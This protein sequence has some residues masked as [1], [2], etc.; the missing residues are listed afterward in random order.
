MA[1]GGLKQVIDS[2]CLPIKPKMK[3]AILDMI[4]EM[5]SI[6]VETSQKSQS[7][8]KNYLAMLLKALIHCNL[9]NCLTQL[10]IEKSDSMA[11]RARKLLKLVITAASDLLPDAPQF[12]LMLDSK[13]SVIAAEIV[14]EIDSS[15]RLQLNSSHQSI[16]FRSCEF[17]SKEPNSYIESHNTVITGIYKNHALNMID[18]TIFNTLMQKSLVLKESITT[19][20]N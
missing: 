9:Y 1:S 15:T 17:L 11:Q 16:L 7:L 5:I 6:P 3:E 4:E 18:D 12:S 14:A 20:W 2:I 8:L 13:K 10:A 19:K